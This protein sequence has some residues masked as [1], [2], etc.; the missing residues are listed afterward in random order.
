M[1]ATVRPA[2]FYHSRLPTFVVD[3]HGRRTAYPR[4]VLYHF[5][6]CPPTFLCPIFTPFTPFFLIGGLEMEATTI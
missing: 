3:W 1:P 4:S 2:E 5:S 6:P